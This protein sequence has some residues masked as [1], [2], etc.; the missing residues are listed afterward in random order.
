MIKTKVCYF[1]PV[2][3][4]KGGAERSLVDLLNNPG[5]E[6]FLALPGCGALSEYAE[7]KNIPVKIMNLGRIKNVVR[8]LSF[9]NII[10]SVFDLFRAAT[11]LKKYCSVNGINKI[12]SNGMKAHAITVLACMFTSIKSII[13][14]RDI[15]ITKLEKI[16]W[17]V[18]FLLSNRVVLVSRACSI[19]KTL[20]SKVCV[21]HNGIN[22]NA[23]DAIKHGIGNDISIGYLGRIHP[24]KGVDW[25][26]GLISYLS[27]E[28]LE[29]SLK[30]KG[31]FEPD[32]TPYHK[33]LLHL[34]DTLSL[35]D[36]VSF[37]GFIDNPDEIYRDVDI[38]FV[39]S[40]TPDPL[41][42]AVME[43]MARGLVVFAFNSGGVIE[44]INHKVN[45]Y[46]ISQDYEESL[47]LLRELIERQDLYNEVSIAAYQHAKK[48]LSI[49]NLYLNINT[50]YSKDL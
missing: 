38:V 7:A 24:T 39:P 50:L 37:E 9:L 42:R 49:S 47:G 20:P 31:E 23:G 35:T 4:F 28:G 10:L 8:P 46:V 12:H 6:P 2:P 19:N 15:P 21:I 3:D 22:V 34:V 13:H 40:I 33:E 44:M 30:I 1:S 17:S 48:N 18:L 14:I 36:K 45:G 29:V 26:I 41:P 5:V 16:T 27:K 43:S 32:T 25:L 11:E